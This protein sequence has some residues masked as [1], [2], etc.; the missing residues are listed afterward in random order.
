MMMNLMQNTSDVK[1]MVLSD[2]HLFHDKTPTVHIVNNLIRTV[3]NNDSMKDID[4][5]VISGDLFDRAVFLPNGDV[6]H[7]HRF[8]HHLV[9][10]CERYDIILR[11]L[12]GTPSHDW[13]QSAM[14][15]EIVK[16]R[17]DTC[18]AKHV[19]VLSIEHIQ[20]LGLDVLYVPDE[21][22]S[23]CASTFNEVKELLIEHQLEKVDIAIMHGCFNYQFPVNLVG[24]PDVHDENSYLGITRYLTVIGHY[25]THSKFERIYVPGSFD[26]LRHNEEEAKGHLLITLRPDE[27]FTVN[28]IENKNA[29]VY[30]TFQ[31]VGLPINEIIDNIAL[32]VKD[33]ERLQFIRIV[34]DKDDP[35]YKGIRE[36]TSLFPFVKFSISLTKDKVKEKVIAETKDIVKPQAITLDNIEQL[37]RERLEQK[38]TEWVVPCMSILK[39][40]IDES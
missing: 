31:C 8:I 34:C 17:G 2:V 6:W 39:E 29:M 27:T 1:I 19:S 5:I 22:G 24:K 7:A 11:V 23:G 10:V 9:N 12:E 4:L 35:I 26:R 33:N 32:F 15:T 37:L 21:W 18:D 38:N 13:K 28:F 30:K 36:L 3:P 16:E 40:V 25:H 14:V 20:R